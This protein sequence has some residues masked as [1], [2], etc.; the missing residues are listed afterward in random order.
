VQPEI[1]WLLSF[2]HDTVVYQG[3]HVLGSLTPLIII[4]AVTLEMTAVFAFLQQLKKESPS[5][6]RVCVCGCVWERESEREREREETNLIS[7]RQLNSADFHKS[8]SGK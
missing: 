8:I 2:V 5:K 1:K 3:L 6:D 4:L 7:I